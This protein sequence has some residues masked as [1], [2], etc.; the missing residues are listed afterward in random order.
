MSQ[1]LLSETEQNFTHFPLKGQTLDP[2]KSCNMNKKPLSSPES[3]FSYF[4]I[5]T[6]PPSPPSPNKQVIVLPA[7]IQTKC[8]PDT[9]LRPSM[10][11]RNDVESL[12]NKPDPQE[13]LPISMKIESPEKSKRRLKYRFILAEA[14]PDIQK[15]LGV[16]AT[17]ET[18]A[19]LTN[20]LPLNFSHSKSMKKES[21]PLQV[22]KLN[23]GKI[24]MSHRSRKSPYPTKSPSKSSQGFTFKLQFP[25]TFS[26]DRIQNIP[27]PINNYKEK[28]E[29]EDENISIFSEDS[30]VESSESKRSFL[31]INKKKTR[32]ASE[33]EG[34]QNSHPRQRRRKG[35]S[36][37][38]VM[39]DRGLIEPS[40]TTM[41]MTNLPTG[42][43][44]SGRIPLPPPVEFSEL[45]KE[46]RQL[47]LETTGLNSRPNV[48][49]KSGPL[50]IEHLPHYEELHPNEAYVASVLRLTPVQYINAKHSLIT[51]KVRYDTRFLPFRKS[52]AQKLLRIDVNKASKLWEYFNELKWI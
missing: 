12:T 49:W 37:A 16:E 51:A 34:I 25:S 14:P 23:K 36:F 1:L 29:S 19:L 27:L 5:S 24:T 17:P 32:D 42:D 26:D 40:L 22:E 47:K 31:A 11:F 8:G 45:I 4:T 15:Q 41:P 6:P 52:D 43:L 10:Q 9:T 44:K 18:S 35:N 28:N 33:F 3:D 30:S 20:S 48:S 13:P 46:L 21:L 50:S 7:K 2:E 39:A 38:R